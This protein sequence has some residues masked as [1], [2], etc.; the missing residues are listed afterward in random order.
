MEKTIL[1][2]ASITA[3]P[4]T[5][6]R[7]MALE[8][9]RSP[10]S[11]RIVRS[12]DAAVSFSASELGQLVARPFA[13][14]RTEISLREAERKSLQPFHPRGEHAKRNQRNSSGDRQRSEATR[15]RAVRRELGDRRIDAARAAE[16]CVSRPADLRRLI[17]HR[18]IDQ[19]DAERRAVA[20]RLL[21]RLMRMPAE[22]PASRVISHRLGIVS[23]IREHLRRFRQSPMT[24][25]PLDA[26]HSV[27][28]RKCGGVIHARRPRYGKL[29]QRAESVVSG[30]NVV[31]A[32]N[33]RGVEIERRG[34]YRTAGRGNVSPSFQ[35]SLA[36]TGLEKIS[37]AANCL[38]VSRM[39]RIR[40]DLFAQPRT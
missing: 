34:K 25:A 39:L 9:L 28:S 20:N 8:R 7:R 2:C 5:M 4:S 17:S 14:Q 15:R 33:V 21:L 36:R 29:R 11:E 31:A 23:R 13:G 22:F 27:H 40:F 12:I 1:S 19:V 35:K 30:A 37:G 16:P 26:T 3:T 18:L 24:R 10:L 32:Q 38:H 6:L